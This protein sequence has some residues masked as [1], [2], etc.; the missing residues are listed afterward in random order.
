MKN[1]TSIVYGWVPLTST[2]VNEDAVCVWGQEEDTYADG[3]VEKRDLH[4]V[5]WFNKE[6]KI[7]RM[8]QWA[9]KFGE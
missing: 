8:R 2:D 7:S 6:G 1:S 9:A 5:W 4:E 3:K